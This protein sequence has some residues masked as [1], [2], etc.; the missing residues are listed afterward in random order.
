MTC[1][2]ILFYENLNFKEFMELSSL[3][4]H[5]KAQAKVSDPRPD[6]APSYSLIDDLARVEKLQK[7]SEAEFQQIVMA[8]MRYKINYLSATLNF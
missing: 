1:P 2:V 6:V 7:L 4:P 3:L 5:E 8:D